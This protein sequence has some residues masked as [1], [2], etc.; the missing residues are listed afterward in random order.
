MSKDNFDDFVDKDKVNALVNKMNR[1]AGQ[2]DDAIRMI[3]TGMNIL[4]GLV[5]RNPI[6]RKRSEETGPLTISTSPEG[7]GRDKEDRDD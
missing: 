6:G 1:F 3:R 2:A 7:K 4:T 5:G